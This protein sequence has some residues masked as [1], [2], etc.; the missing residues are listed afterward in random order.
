MRRLRRLSFVAAGVISVGAVATG[1]SAAASTRPALPATYLSP[2]TPAQIQQLS[3][4]SLIHIF[5]D[6]GAASLAG[7]ILKRDPIHHAR[8]ATGQ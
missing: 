3:A 5:I 2:L 6:H 1:G 4:L 7:E 8:D